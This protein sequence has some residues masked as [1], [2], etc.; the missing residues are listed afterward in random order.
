MKKILLMLVGGTICTAINDEGNLSVSEKAGALLKENYIN[1]AS[2]Y[3][4]DV[5]IVLTENL[6]ILSE[7]M[8][9]EKWNVIIETYKKHLSKENFDGIIIA[10]GTDTLAYSASLLS[11]V[12]DSSKT[13][14]FL[15]SANKNLK[16]DESN[17][18]H[19]FGCAVECICRNIPPN[20]YVPYKNISDGR[21]YLHLASRL[22]QCENYSDDFLSYGA[23]DITDISEDNYFEYFKKLEKMYPQEKRKTVVSDDLKL[24]NCVLKLVPYVGIN[25][26]A[27]DYS[28]FS[29]VLHGTFHSGTACVQK[30]KGYT[31]SSVLYML[32]KCLSQDI[33]VY[34]SPSVN[35]HGTYETVSIIANHKVNQN[36]IKFLYGCTNEMAY[37]KLVIAYSLF[38]TDNEI[39]EFMNTEFN[40]ENWGEA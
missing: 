20:V 12:L 33:P 7:N 24:K 4:K 31:E 8:T 40:F 25:Y 21:T 6:Y 22:R 26:S 18:N 28:K 27:F 34:L 2:P 35:Y 16:S 5:D 38:R 10:H 19:N 32:D 3:A 30:E 23:L 39:Q 17:G 11:L 14:V 15:V 29:A 36:K 13:P 1:S 37:A 9:V